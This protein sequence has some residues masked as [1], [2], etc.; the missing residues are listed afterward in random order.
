MKPLTENEQFDNARKLSNEYRGGVPKELKQ[1]GDNT[2]YTLHNLDIMA[3]PP[4]DIRICK[5]QELEKRCFDYVEICMRNDMKPTMA[6][7]AL[8]LNMSRSA[9]LDYM[10]GNYPMPTVNR[11]VLKRFSGLLNSLMEDFLMNGKVNPV[12]G[13]F[14]AKNDYGYKDSQEFVVNN[15]SEQVESAETLLEEAKLL[16]ET[17]P[18]M[19]NLEG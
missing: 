7:L 12:A 4:L 2:K 8:S 5:Q 19:A 15:Q 10:N 16:T 14:I 13:I 1:A 9:L 3:L 11:E 18:K 6:G 17:E